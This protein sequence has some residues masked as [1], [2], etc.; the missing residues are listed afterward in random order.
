MQGWV[1]NIMERFGYFG[2]GFLIAVE[3]LFPPI[4]SELILTFGG[5]LTTQTALRLPGMI[6]YATLGSLTGAVLLY[7]VG[8]LLDRDR[9]DALLSCSLI[10]RLGFQKQSVLDSVER[11][12]KEGKKLVLLGRFVP[13]VR[14]LVS[15]PAGMAHMDFCSFLWLTALGSAVWNGVLL[16]LGAVAGAS[17]TLLAERCSEWM[18]LVK[19]L[20]LAGGGLAL[21][22]HIVRKRTKKEKQS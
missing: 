2:M 16:S 22:F 1:L 3:N 8:R 20:I 11:F 17:W 7:G 12:G 15:I 9:L 18:G 6:L 14:S 13:I 4:P 21:A 19:I 10:E 5:F